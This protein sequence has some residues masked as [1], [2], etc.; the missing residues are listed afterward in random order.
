MSNGPKET[1]ESLQYGNRFGEISFGTLNLAG[2]GG[3]EADVLTGVKLQAYNSLHYMQMENDG[4]R[5]GW[6]MTRCPGVW[7][8]KCADTVQKGDIGGYLHVENG[9]LVIKAPNGRI[10]IQAVDIDLRADGTNERTGYINIESNNTVSVKT[11]QFKVT[12]QNG[13]N[14]FSPQAVKIASNTALTFAS[15]FVSGVTSAS[16]IFGAKAFPD[17]KTQFIKNNR[18]EG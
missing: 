4:Y 18:Y 16:N 10:R 11:G 7:E 15:N 8:V 2:T 9:D 5:Q 12:A 17:S 13:V 6:T 1:F 3:L 14:V